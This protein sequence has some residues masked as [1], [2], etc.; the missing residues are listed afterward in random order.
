MDPHRIGGLGLSVG[1]EML[2][3]TAAETRDLAA[4]VAEG[5]GARTMGEEMDDVDGLEKVGAALTYGI[6]DL[7]N[8]ILQNRTPPENL[9]KLIPQIAPRPIFFIHAGADDAGHLGPDYYSIAGGP[10]QIWEAKGGHT[11]GIEKQPA[12]Y[13]RRVVSFF[14][15]SL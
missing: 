13:E 2:L 7:S 9:K 1:A 11:Q 15:R 4:I 5:A 6:R 14:D 10:K 12:E 8:S 3:E